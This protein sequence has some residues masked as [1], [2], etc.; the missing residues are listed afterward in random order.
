MNAVILAGRDGTL[1]SE[2]GGVLTRLGYVP[3]VAPRLDA[4]LGAARAAQAELLVIADRLEDARPSD[5]LRAL[6]ADLATESLPVVVLGS[7]ADDV[8][9]I[10]ALELG[11]D[12]FLAWPPNERELALRLSALHRR[13]RTVPG[14]SRE[15]YG[16]V[17]VQRDD[18][19]VWVEGT[20]VH[21]SAGQ[22]RI[23]LT[24]LSPVG[25]VH[26]RDKI[27]AALGPSEQADDSRF[28][29]ARVARLRERLG[30]AG[31]CIETVRGVGYRFVARGED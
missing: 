13:S 16:P 27:R 18:H 2:I 22:L 5:L 19:R 1:R 29:D 24:L 3:L 10:V 26:S 8:E 21:I 7:G 12:E 17:E 11:A 14:R 9:R 6:R 23:L 28:I 15:R 4:A 20:A 30:V 31:N 25:A